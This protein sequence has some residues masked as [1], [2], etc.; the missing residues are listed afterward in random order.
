ML[1]GLF[2]GISLSSPINVPNKFFNGTVGDIPYTVGSSSC[3]QNVFAKEEFDVPMRKISWRAWAIGI[4]IVLAGVV[5]LTRALPLFSSHHVSSADKAKLSFPARATVTIPLHQNLFSPFILP[6]KVN[7]LVTWKNED[8]VLHNFATTPNQSAF[9]NP[10]P[11]AFAL[12]PGHEATFLFSRPGVYHYYDTIKDR[13]DTTYGRVKAYPGTVHYPEAMDGAIWVQGSIKELPSTALAFVLA[14]HDMFSPEFLAI[15]VDGAVT[16]HNL[17]T[18]PHFVG[19]VAGWSAPINPVNIGIYRLAGTD[20]VPG[21]QSV[22][23]LFSKPGL[24]YYYCRNH[25][26][27]DPASNRAVALPMASEYPIPMEGFVLVA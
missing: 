16:W 24:Y 18:D 19:L 12:A 11:F 14:G 21:G 13:W 5:A 25:D 17:D 23:V 10:R 27:I 2:V 6:I 15:A 4:I 26:I 8:T 22:T 7:T 20:G 3:Y 9:L 1:I